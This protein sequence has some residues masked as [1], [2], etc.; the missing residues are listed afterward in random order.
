MTTPVAGKRIK[1]FGHR[2]EPKAAV[3][4]RRTS[5]RWP[6][7]SSLNLLDDTYSRM[8]GLVG[9]DVVKILGH[10]RK[11]CETRRNMGVSECTPLLD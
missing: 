2:W 1:A 8:C 5:S 10:R 7:N 11:Q 6:L 4:K 3:Q 9:V